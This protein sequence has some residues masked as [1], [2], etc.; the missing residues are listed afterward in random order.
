V[1]N[2]HVI[3]VNQLLTY[4]VLQIVRRYD[5]TLIQE[6]RDSSEMVIYDFLEIVNR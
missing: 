1:P 5:I 4:F 6:I 2:T 3:A